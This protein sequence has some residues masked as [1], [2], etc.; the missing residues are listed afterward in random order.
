M[1]LIEARARPRDFSFYIKFFLP[2]EESISDERGNNDAIEMDSLTTSAA[3]DLISFNPNFAIGPSTAGFLA[4]HY[5][6]CEAASSVVAACTTEPSN[7][8]KISDAFPR[9]ENM[10]LLKEWWS[11]RVTNA[12]LRTTSLAF[13]ASIIVLSARFITFLS[14]FSIGIRK[15]GT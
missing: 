10:R 3:I 6:I 7:D 1:T 15:K 8:S 4:K 2:G 9:I 12:L 11:K 14:K 13:I 5:A